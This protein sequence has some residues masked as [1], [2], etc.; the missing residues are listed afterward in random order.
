MRSALANDGVQLDAQ[1]KSLGLA[2]ASLKLTRESYRVGNVG[3]LQVLDSER[4]LQ[5]AQLGYLEAQTSR[6]QDTLALY[7]ALG[8]SDPQVTAT[9]TANA[10]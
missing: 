6:Y 7:L 4:Q 8:G 3:V 2:Q 5:R 9:K 1:T 10:Q